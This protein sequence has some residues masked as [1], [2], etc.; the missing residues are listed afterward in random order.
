MT[1]AP[2]TRPGSVMELL[3]GEPLTVVFGWQQPVGGK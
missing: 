1:L 2:G 3:E